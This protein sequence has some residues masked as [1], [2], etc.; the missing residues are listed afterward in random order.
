[1]V[2]TFLLLACIIAV[3]GWLISNKVHID[4]KSFFRKGFSKYDDNYGVYCMNGQQ[5]NG[6]TYTIFD[7]VTDMYLGKK[8][9]YCN[10]KSF[11]DS[12][13]GK[14][15]IYEN[16]FNKLVEKFS[17]IDDCSD[18]IIIFD[19]I[20]SLVEKGKID[21]EKLLFLSQMRKRKLNF[22][23]TCQEWAELNLTF[24]RYCRYKVDCKMFNLPL[25]NCALIMFNIYN[26]YDTHWSSE[27]NDF[28]SPLI[29]TTLKK[30][31]LK[32][33]QSYDT[34]ETIKIVNSYGKVLTSY[35]K[36]PS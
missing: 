23:T 2:I 31:S 35:N 10:V 20:F 21:K 4:L 12:Y 36:S 18:Y 27:D 32:V 6:K 34:F 33:V 3:V 8:T 16:D 15:V 19:E 9:I 13:R 22:F 29:R 30:C 24:R 28:V 1:M 7:I 17:N 5:G 14:G 26:G 25:F 11:C